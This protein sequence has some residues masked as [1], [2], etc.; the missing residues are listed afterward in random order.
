MYAN[1]TVLRKQIQKNVAV[2]TEGS[3]GNFEE[4][5]KFYLQKDSMAVGK[6]YEL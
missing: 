5:I 2:A 4:R 3:K 6:R 1:E